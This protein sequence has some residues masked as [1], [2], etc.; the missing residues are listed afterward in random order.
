MIYEYNAKVVRIVDGDTV[1][2]DVDLGFGIH[3]NLDFRLLGINTPEIVG[4]TKVAG[5]AAKAELQRL[6]ALGSLRVETHK[7]DK[8]GR[9]LATLFV[10]PGDGA[11]V[12]V[13]AQ[14]ELGKFATP[15]LGEGPKS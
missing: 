5:L 4:A 15:Y 14:L 6:L 11:E 8:Y 10:K 13:N 1:W 7:S 2:L 9:W 12:N 3:A